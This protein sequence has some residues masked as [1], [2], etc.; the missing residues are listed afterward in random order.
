M[1]HNTRAL[2]LFK[3][4]MYKQQLA[5]SGCG[6][7]NS[8]CE[9]ILTHCFTSFKWFGMNLVI[10]STFC[11]P[12]W[13]QCLLWYLHRNES[14]V[15]HICA[16]RFPALNS[17]LGHSWTTSSLTLLPVKLMKI[18][19]LALVGT[20][21]GLPS[22]CVTAVCM[23]KLASGWALWA[24]AGWALGGVSTPATA[25]CP[26]EVSTSAV[27]IWPLWDQTLHLL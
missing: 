22:P 16:F 19:S 5:E 6:F 21:S 2:S 7:R 20:R 3:D 18:L 26:S 14:P 17:S 10:S 11:A 9:Q 15:P 8:S 24:S 25:A 13:C 1:Y 12:G 23:E 4:Q 27:L